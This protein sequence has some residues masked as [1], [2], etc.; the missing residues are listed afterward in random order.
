MKTPPTDKV[1]AGSGFRV[2]H[3]QLGEISCFAPM[4]HV[5][6]FNGLLQPTALQKKANP[7]LASQWLSRDRL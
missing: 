4:I 2:G 7:F 1:P 5:L 3:V 6:C